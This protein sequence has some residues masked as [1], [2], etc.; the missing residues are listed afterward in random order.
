MK[1]T[2]FLFNQYQYR[3]IGKYKDSTFCCNPE[4]NEMKVKTCLLVV[5]LLSIEAY[6]SHPNLMYFKLAGLYYKF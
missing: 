6:A 4:T 1:I 2:Y 5:E 3:N